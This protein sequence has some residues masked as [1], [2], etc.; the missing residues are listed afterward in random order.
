MYFLLCRDPVQRAQAR[1]HALAVASE[2]Q[3]FGQVRILEH[4]ENTLHQNKKDWIRHWITEGFVGLERNVSSTAKEFC[5]GDQISIADICLVPQ[6]FNA[7]LW[8]V[9]MTQ[10][11]TLSRIDATLNQHPAFIAAHAYSQ[12]DAPPKPST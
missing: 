11:P 5:V 4:I 10:F 12:P 3:P 9:D 8:D 2:I 6:I 1:G 7:R